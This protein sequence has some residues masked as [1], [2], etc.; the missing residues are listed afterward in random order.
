MSQPLT[1]SKQW[2]WNAPGLKWNGTA[3]QNNKTMATNSTDAPV[4]ITITPAQKTAILAQIAD[5]AALITFGVGLSDDQRRKLLKLGTK[6]VGWDEKA[7][8]YM[9]S[10]PELIPAYVDSAAL[11][12]NRQVRVDLGDI[13]HAISAVVQNLTDTQMIIGNQI[14][15]PEL[16]FYN[17]AAEAAKHGVPNAQAIADDLGSRFPGPNGHSTAT[18]TTPAGSQHT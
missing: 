3:P 16:A 8:S 6:T 11:S 7:A 15:K 10:H 5:L 4:V 17:S 2:R 18:G 14:L 12:Q 9:A 13:I 1:W